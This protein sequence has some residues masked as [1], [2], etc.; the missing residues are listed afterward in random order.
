MPSNILLSYNDLIV[1]FHHRDS[2]D[3]PN[4]RCRRT[5]DDMTFTFGSRDSFDLYNGCPFRL[6]QSQLSATES[7]VP[8]DEV[9]DCAPKTRRSTLK[10]LKTLAKRIGEVIR[11]REVEEDPFVTRKELE[12]RA[13]IRRA[14]EIDCCP[15]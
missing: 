6:S 15:I 10:K 7:S 4:I 14:K 8:G 3:L 9:N 11:G 1:P 5:T 2:L 13:I 12:R